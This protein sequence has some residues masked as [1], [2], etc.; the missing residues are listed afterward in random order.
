VIRFIFFL[1]AYFLV[2]SSLA[3][4]TYSGNIID[5]QD[6]GF[7]EGVK[8]QSVSSGEEVLSNSRGYFSISA[9]LGDTLVFSRIYFTA[10][11]FKL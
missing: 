7:L 2:L 8:V 3:Q 4:R 5:S 9:F 1:F 11:S 10:S 6:K